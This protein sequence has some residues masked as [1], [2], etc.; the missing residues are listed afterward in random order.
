MV[1]QPGRLPGAR[2]PGVG[3]PAVLPMSLAASY[4]REAHHRSSDAAWHASDRSDDQQYTKG[5]AH[6]SVSW[7]SVHTL[8][9]VR[10][11]WRVPHGDRPQTSCHHSATNDR[12]L[13][14]AGTAV[15]G[16]RALR[17]RWRMKGTHKWCPYTHA[18]KVCR[19]TGRQG[20]RRLRCSHRV[21]HIESNTRE[22][23]AQTR[24]EA[25]HGRG[26]TP[27]DAMPVRAADEG[28]DR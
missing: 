9:R 28:A 14:G 21:E 10:S 1:A 17:R 19:A 15:V 2:V 13:P 24:S 11:Q 22:N 27:R 6:T 8:L 5:A 4:G 12:P 16:C 25:G 18:S 20:W 23:A 26:W 3:T 7:R